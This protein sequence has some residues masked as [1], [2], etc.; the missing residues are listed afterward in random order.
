M[1]EDAYL[2]AKALGLA[3]WCLDEAGPFSTMPYLGR[4]WHPEGQ[5][6]RLN[7]EYF[8]NGTARMLTLFHPES[9]QLR[10]K[11]VTSTANAILHPWLKAQLTEVLAALPATEAPSDPALIQAA[12][13]RWSE[14]L[15]VPP[16]R[17]ETLPPLRL[18]LVLDNLAGHKTPSWV[19]WCAQHGIALLYTPLSGSWLNMAESIQGLIKARALHGSS[20]TEP[21]QIITALEQAVTAWNRAP[22]PFI[23]GGKRAARRVRARQRRQARALALSGACI[24][25][26]L[27]PRSLP[28][29]AKNGTVR[30]N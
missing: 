24:R 2:G 18:L 11:G 12:W 1:I 13:A 29:A 30:A 15:A 21:A 20:P 23:W 9:G 16:P 22:T 17:A 19:Q 8:P 27:R 10:A 6:A 28:Q 25:R 26:A 7:H 5:P 14:G 4:G 3:V